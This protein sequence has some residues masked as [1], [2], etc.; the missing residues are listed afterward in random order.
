MAQIT[1][2]DLNKAKNIMDA[3][4]TKR[5]N[6]WSGSASNSTG[7]S[8]MSWAVELQKCSGSFNVSRNS[9]GTYTGD[10]CSGKFSDKTCQNRCQGFLTALLAYKNLQDNYVS[11]KKNYD[12]LVVNYNA[13]GNVKAKKTNITIAASIIAGIV[14]VAIGFFVAKKKNLI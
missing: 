9:A 8:V 6:E 3:L 1:Q 4:F 11:A 5:E 12:D 10:D 14:L 13:Q 2:D 7:Y